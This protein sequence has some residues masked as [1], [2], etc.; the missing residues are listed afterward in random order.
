MRTCILMII[1]CCCIMPIQ[2]HALTVDAFIYQVEAD[3]PEG[4]LEAVT[5]LQQGLC[6]VYRYESMV[7][8]PEY[9]GEVVDQAYLDAHPGATLDYE[10]GDIPMIPNPETCSDYA[11]RKQA[12]WFNS[13]PYRRDRPEIKAEIE[14]AAVAIIEARKTGKGKG[15][16][17]KAQQ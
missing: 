11:N 8:D 6:R 16:I 17:K 10:F 9:S 15:L 13:L 12:E 4:V 14:A 1:L 2:A 5:E 3:T 7:P